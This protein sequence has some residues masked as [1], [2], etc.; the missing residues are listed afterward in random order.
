MA[1]HSKFRIG[2]HLE[3]ALDLDPQL[4]PL[5]TLALDLVADLDVGRDRLDLF[6]LFRTG[7]LIGVGSFLSY[8]P[9]LKNIKQTP[10][11]F[12]R[13]ERFDC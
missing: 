2:P 6:N 13:W 8:N 5:Q 1:V 10:W 12:I 4:D 7:S 11:M 9:Y 3:V